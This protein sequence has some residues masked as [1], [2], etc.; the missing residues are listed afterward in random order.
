MIQEDS[1]TERE[2]KV[3]TQ[4]KQEA[5]GQEGKVIATSVATQHHYHQEISHPRSDVAQMSLILLS[6]MGMSE[7]RIQTQGQ[8]RIK[9]EIRDLVKEQKI[10]K[11]RADIRASDRFREID[12]DLRNGY[13][14][15]IRRHQ[16]GHRS[17][18]VEVEVMLNRFHSPPLTVKRG[19]RSWKS[20]KPRSCGGTESCFF[21]SIWWEPWQPTSIASEV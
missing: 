13:T 20:D 16:V 5:G 14:K 4:F 17:P 21:G 2:E 1:T 6:S 11:N 15:D 18:F 3:S 19:R 9:K 12:R 7:E 10:E 8:R